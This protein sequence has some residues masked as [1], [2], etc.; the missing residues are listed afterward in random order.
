M[1]TRNLLKG[2]SR[3]ANP[4]AMYD[5]SFIRYVNELDSYFKASE[6][7][8]QNS[9]DLAEATSSTEEMSAENR[10]SMK[11]RKFMWNQQAKLTV[12]PQIS[13]NSF[14]VSSTEL[15]TL[16]VSMKMNTDSASFYATPDQDLSFMTAP[17]G[18]SLC[19]TPD[20]ATTSDVSCYL[21]AEQNSSLETDTYVYEIAKA[22]G[23][24]ETL[25]NESIEYDESSDSLESCEASAESCAA[26]ISLIDLN[27]N[28]SEENTEIDLEAEAQ[29]VLC[30]LK[31]KKIKVESVTKNEIQANDTV[32]NSTF[33]HKLQAKE[34]RSNFV[35]STCIDLE[36][37]VKNNDN[38]D[39]TVIVLDE[40]EPKKESYLKCCPV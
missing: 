21:T 15:D 20:Q 27:E 28:E 8:H 1:S 9:Q 37:E 34:R 33:R 29:D 12:I 16:E 30:P 35:R 24:Q 19:L 11:R 2:Y 4:Y 14:D 38:Q 23:S 26:A 25:Y 39:T 13:L 18:Q 10:L 22:H 5:E 31:E 3:K 32:T 40:K 17:D 36:D 6:L 7:R